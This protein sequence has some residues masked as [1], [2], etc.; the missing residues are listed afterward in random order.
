MS[1]GSSSSSLLQRLAELDVVLALLGGDRD[2]QHR[3]IGRRPSTTGGCACLPAVS[4]SPVLAWSS[5]PSATVSP[6]AAGAALLGGL[7][8]QL[9][10][11]G[12]AAGFALG[13]DEGRAVADLAGEHARDRH[14]AAVRGVQRLDHIGDRIAAGLDAEALGGVGDAR[15][16]VAQRLHQPQH[17]VGAR[18]RARSAPGRP[19]RR[20]VPWRDRRTPC[21]AAA[22]CPRAA[23]P[24]ARRRD[25]RA[26]PAW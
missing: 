5:L 15:R 10:H 19:G 6:A 18:R 14:L 13:R 24:S 9:E 20:A 25:R 26:S 22:E 7:A 4:V 16:L 3:R 17:A 11:A 8:D 23:A 1:E 12:D 21:R 2:R